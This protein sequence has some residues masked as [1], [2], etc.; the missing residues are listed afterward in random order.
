M[1]GE[2]LPLLRRLPTGRLARGFVLTA[3]VKLAA[4]GLTLSLQWVLVR[5]LGTRGY[6]DFT[7]AVTW[8]GA[9]LAVVAFGLQEATVRFVAEYRARRDAAGLRGFLAWSRRRALALGLAAAAGGLGAAA[10]LGRSGHSALA[11]TAVPV[12]LALAPGAMLLLTGALLRAEERFVP[13]QAPVQVVQ[14]AVV[15]ALAWLAVSRLGLRAAASTAGWAFLVAVVAAYC[16]SSAL[17]APSLRRL[18]AG[19]ARREPRRWREA[20]VHLVGLAVVPLLA[21]TDVMMLGALAGT[22]EAGIYAAAVHLA[23][24]IETGFNLLTSVTMARI[25]A[26]HAA[27]DR[28]GLAR[29]MRPF[30]AAAAATAVPVAA[31]L[32]VAGGPVLSLF[33]ADFVAARLPL[34]V[35]ALGGLIHVLTGPVARLLTMTGHHRPALRLMIAAAVANLVLNALLIPPLGAL[36]AAAATASAM[37]ATKIAGVILVRRRL[38]I[39][40]TV[41]SLLRR[42]A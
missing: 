30:S 18:G 14:P 39:D 27:D 28:R 37:V 7:Y 33:G 4:M 41:M 16:T 38:G 17:A 9:I 24:V 2:R 22:R 3:G 10:L 12:A 21:R 11:A 8:Y 25:A 20:T 42:R 26:L 32:V 6:G 1:M 13:A 34:A 31:V 35:L 19:E 5:L 29:L 36:G 40:P 23:T 15:M